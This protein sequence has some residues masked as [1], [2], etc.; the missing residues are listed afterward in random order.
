MLDLMA[1]YQTDEKA[2]KGCW[3]DFLIAIASKVHFSA[4][5]LR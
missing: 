3:Y 4:F 5:T 1:N 2:K